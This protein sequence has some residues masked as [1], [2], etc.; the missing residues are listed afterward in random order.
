ML[1]PLLRALGL[2]LP[3]VRDLVKVIETDAD[4]V[5]RQ[6]CEAPIAPDYVF[7]G[8]KRKTG[9]E[10]SGLCHWGA[11]TI[12]WVDYVVVGRALLSN[13]DWPPVMPYFI[14]FFSFRCLISRL[15]AE[16]PDRDFYVVFEHGGRRMRF[17]RRGGETLHSGY[18]DGRLLEQPNLYLRK[19]VMY[20]PV[21][22]DFRY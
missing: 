2:P 16:S 4:E 13:D 18:G 22:C 17:E 3:A 6:L 14:A 10:R 8:L 1:A 21:P 20:V 15:V 7:E 11:D 19:I 12:Q 9:W 5:R